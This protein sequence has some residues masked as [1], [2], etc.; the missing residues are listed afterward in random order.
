MP[1]VEVRYLKPEES[2][3]PFDIVTTYAFRNT[4]APYPAGYGESEHLT[5]IR[6]ESLEGRRAFALFEDEKPVA[7][8]AYFTMTQNVRGQVIPMAGVAPVAALPEGRR[9]GYA[10]QCVIKSYEDMR[11]QGYAITSLYPFRESFYERLGYVT[12]LQPRDWKFNPASFSAVLKQDLEGEV[13]YYESSKYP[14]KVIEFYQH[15]QKRIHGFILR[16][17]FDLRNRVIW[18]NFWLAEAVVDGEMTIRDFY[19]DTAQA[20]YLLL[21]WIARH[22]DQQKSAHMR[23]P[24]FE[25]PETWWAD[26]EMQAQTL[27]DIVGMVRVLDVMK[28]SG[29][30][31]GNGVFRAKIQDDQCE[32]NNGTFEFRAENGLLVVEPIDT[33]DCELTIQG[34]SAVVFGTHDIGSLQWRGWG[35]PSS[36][37]Q[38]KIEGVFPQ[39]SPYIHSRF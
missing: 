2:H 11:E 16:P 14:D 31:V 38:S 18:Q 24:H 23:L 3:E 29:L 28:L 32:W 4:P 27:D 21:S 9:K 12:A 17:E 10:R 15:H 26:V 19:Y 33:A 1:K 30:P 6:R 20:R 7:V 22:A 25:Q 36:V 35:N 37:I 13:N 34:L 5:K 39:I 8:T